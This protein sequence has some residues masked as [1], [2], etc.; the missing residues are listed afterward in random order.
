MNKSELVIAV[1]AAIADGKAKQRLC[2][3]FSQSPGGNTIDCAN[4]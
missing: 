3:G 4:S 2:S 1:E